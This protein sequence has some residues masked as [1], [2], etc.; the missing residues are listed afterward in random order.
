MNKLATSLIRTLL[1]LLLPVA[2]ARAGVI[3]SPHD[4]TKKSWNTAA[5]S[6]ADPNSV[7]GPCH[8]AHKT[9]SVAVVPLWAH[10]TATPS[11][12]KMYNTANVPNSQMKATVESVPQGASLSCLSCHDGTVAVNQMAGG[13]ILGGTPEQISLKGNI[14]KDGNNVV[15]PGDL[16]HSH[17]ISMVYNTALL[18]K[19][20]G[21]FDPATAQVLTP[22]AA[23]V[24]LGN[25]P[26]LTI[27]NFL[28]TGPNKDHLE[29]TSC[30]DVHDSKGVAYDPVTNPNMV[31]ITGTKGGKGS[32][33]CRSCHDK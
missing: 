19:D 27:K 6:P 30:H 11:S 22:D 1:L 21:L 20:H 2:T 24:R 16:T 15:H 3:D 32:L 13:V 7:C 23:T 10:D 4:F 12:F 18:T 28:L 29:C 14:T 31:L 8:Q 25:S 33:L 17:P 26:D 9:D 5:S